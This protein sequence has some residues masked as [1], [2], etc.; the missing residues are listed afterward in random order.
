[1]SQICKN[2]MIFLSIIIFK[3]SHYTESKS[4]GITLPWSKKDVEVKVSR[5][6]LW[7][8]FFVAEM[9]FFPKKYK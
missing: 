3:L 1:M 5:S 4:C 2:C 8:F 9:G 6:Q 7:Q